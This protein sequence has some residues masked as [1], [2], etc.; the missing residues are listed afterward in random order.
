VTTLFAVALS[1]I[2]VVAGVRCFDVRSVDGG[3]VV[4]QQVAAVWSYG[5]LHG[6]IVANDFPKGAG[7]VVGAT[8]GGDVGTPFFR[9]RHDRIRLAGRVTIDGGLLLHDDTRAHFDLDA[10]TFAAGPQLWLRI[11]PAA[12]FVARA[13]VGGSV[14]FFDITG[15]SSL[16]VSP[17]VDAAVGFAFDLF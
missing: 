8:Y 4:S 12:F 13:A 1:A 14:F 3:C 10:I 16:V 9:F 15:R 2:S 11:S 17:T 5:E 6:A 7:I